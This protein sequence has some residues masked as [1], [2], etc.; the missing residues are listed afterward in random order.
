[1]KI[2]FAAQTINDITNDPE[3]PENLK[4][5]TSDWKEF[6]ACRQRK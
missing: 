4:Y 1:L 2:D 5:K 6:V 3:S